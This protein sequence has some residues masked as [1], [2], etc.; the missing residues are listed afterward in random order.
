MVFV[1]PKYYFIENKVL[2]VGENRLKC[3]PSDIGQLSSLL[4]FDAA[5]CQLTILPE[6]LANCTALTKLWVS[7]NRFVCAHTRTHT[8][9]HAHTYYTID[10]CRLTR[11]PARIGN[12]K[13]LKELHL[14]TNQLRYYPF[15][16]TE[17]DVYTINGK[18]PILKDISVWPICTLDSSLQPTVRW[19][20][21]Q[22]YW[23]FNQNTLRTNSS[24]PWTIREGNRHGLQWKPGELPKRLEGEKYFRE[25]AKS[26]DYNTIQ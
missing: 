10:T 23:K 6:S 25:K 2:Y 24:S 11:L 26:L 12:L 20:R 14:R 17:L 19:F 16:I 9:T 5:S 1:Y 13:E 8:H 15:S 3:L 21:H 4:E 7:R 18:L 22:N